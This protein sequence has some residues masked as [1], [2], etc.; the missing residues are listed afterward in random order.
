MKTTREIA[1]ICG[2][3]EQAVRAWCRKINIANNVARKFRN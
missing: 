3:S 2:V 1:E